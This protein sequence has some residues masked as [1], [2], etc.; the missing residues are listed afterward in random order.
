[1]AGK[2]R[3]HQRS[4]SILTSTTILAFAFGASEV[5]QAQTAYSVPSGANLATAVPTPVNGDSWN[6]QGSAFLYSTGTSFR[7]TIPIGSPG[8][9]INGAAGGSTI[10][11]NNGAG[12]YGGLGGGGSPLILTL[13]NVTFTGGSQA[14]G[15]AILVSN[16]LVL[17]TAGTVAFNNNVA[18]S[19]SVGDGGGAINSF[20]LTVNGSLSLNSNRGQVGGALNVNGLTVNGNLTAAN[21]TATIG[22]GVAYSFAPVLVTGNVTLISNTATAIYASSNSISLA[23]QTGDVVLQN[24]VSTGGGGALFAGAITLGNGGGVVTLTGNSS[25][26]GGVMQATGLLT[27]SG[28]T[29]TIS[30]NSSTGIGG[31]AII[32]TVAANITSTGVLTISNNTSATIGGALQVSG[33]LS[34]TGNRIVLNDNRALNGN[35]GGI[36]NSTGVTIN[37]AMEANNNSAQNGNG[38]VIHASRNNIQANGTL[39]ASNNTASLAG[40]VFNVAIGNATVTGDTNLTGNTASNG[41]GG[42]INASGNVALSTTSGNVILAGNRALGTGRGGALF[43]GGTIVLGNPAAAIAIGVDGTGNIAGNSAVGDGGALYS[44]GTTTLTGTA[45]AISNNTS[46]GNGGA[47]YSTGAFSLTANAAST[48]ANNHSDHKG[49]AIWAN[50]AVTLNAIGGDIVFT[51][52]THEDPIA[53]AVYLN[54]GLGGSL[55]TFNADTGRSIV[56]FDPIMNNAANGLVSVTKT[57]DGL[58]SFDGSRYSLEVDRWS[59][60]Y[61]NTQVQSGVFEIANNAIYGALASDVGGATPTSF[62]AATGTTLQGGAVGTVRADTLT[63][64]GDLSI[65]GRQPGTRGVFTMASRGVSFG[66][67]SQV[68][69]NTYLNDASVQNTDLLVL[70]L[71]G[72]STA[73]TA[74]VIVTNVGG[75]GG[76]TIGDGIKLVQTNNGSSA[77]AFVLPAAVPGGAYEY[78]LFYG[79]QG[80]NAAD[81]NWYLR[82]IYVPPNDN[83]GGDN[84]GGSNSGGGNGTDG[85]LLPDSVPSLTPSAQTAMAYTDSLMTFAGATLGTLQQRTGNRIWPGDLTSTGIRCSDP[86][87]ND[88][89]LVAQGAWGRIGGQHGKYSP[90]GHGIN[91]SPYSQ[92]LG[93]LQA[94]Y[95]GV[96]HRT[97]LGDITVGFYGTVGKSRVEVD[98]SRDPVTGTSRGKGTIDTTGYGLGANVTWLGNNG[99][100][101]DAIGQATFYNSDLS[102]APFRSNNGWSSVLSL[103][104]GQRYEFGSGW[105]AVPQAQLAWTHV[106]F[107]KFLDQNGAFVRSGKGDSLLGRVGVRLEKL[108]SWRGDDGAMH[109]LQLYG[110]A[111]LYHEFLNDRS[112]RINAVELNQQ[113]RKLWGEVGLGGTYS[114]N[115]KWSLY[116]EASYAT[117]GGGNNYNI[118]GIVGLRVTW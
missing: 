29:V 7:K 118:K 83:G 8:L 50:S 6:L 60:V 17:N 53:N 1:M 92:N 34:L 2:F 69:F 115:D 5:S 78:G 3:L 9:T 43:A 108:A 56:F 114:R 107:D 35:G 36:L 48:V 100:Y 96:A 45:I 90:D 46:A 103:E 81:G 73:G 89:C 61:G 104:V 18:T 87:Q 66:S 80:A 70:D 28:N 117:A 76:V 11:L 25:A 64:N 44:T 37:G 4:L 75:P 49:G 26:G 14:N 84:G 79:G 42:G 15:G 51:G 68:L 47:I 62:V 113:G 82:T 111:N 74:N 38:G 88:R 55:A 112:V 106:D 71:N 63:L 10:T 13:S 31:G 77:G 67:A 65:A 72:S 93:F 97:M 102:N 23:T 24:N 109:R 54:N 95:E 22:G 21:N 85:P 58:L 39:T 86:A 52:N 91:A 40:G 20:A 41:N 57:G 12:N 116:G 33:V 27:I 59:K 105:A 110:I 101:A 32:A 99:F 19:T 16:D 94:G 30:N 98:L